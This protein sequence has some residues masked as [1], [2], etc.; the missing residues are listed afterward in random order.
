MRV[1]KIELAPK[2][3]TPIELEYDIGNETFVIQ[4]STDRIIIEKNDI[5]EFLEEFE[6]FIK[7]Q[8]DV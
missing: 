3:Y 7:G 2:T 4:Q 8:P 6:S 1:S 5:W